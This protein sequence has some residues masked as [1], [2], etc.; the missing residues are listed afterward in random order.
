[1]NEPTQQELRDML[2]AAVMQRNAAHGETLQVYA[3]LK[4]SERRVADLA[5]Q[6]ERLSTPTE[7]PKDAA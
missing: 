4:A 5:A 7:V 1:M 2:D 6:L 3:Q